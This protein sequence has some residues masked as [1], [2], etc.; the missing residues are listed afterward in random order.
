M[1]K[2][3]MPMPGE[4]YRNGHGDLYQVTAVALHSITKEEE[5]V[6]QALFGEFQYSVIPLNL[7]LDENGCFERWDHLHP[8]GG[9]TEPEAEPASDDPGMGALLEFLDANTCREKWNI[10]M[11]M[12]KELD[13]HLLNS[14]T[15]SLDLVVTEERFEERLDRV[16]DYLQT[17]IRFE[18]Q[19]M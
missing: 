14:I 7:F 15:A 5:V 19:R 6:C 10:L 4:I 16:R 9:K 3:T 11:R 13:D 12:E 18:D 8:T 2:K 1:I 17:R